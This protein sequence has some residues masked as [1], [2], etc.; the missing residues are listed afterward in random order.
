MHHLTYFFA[1]IL[2]SCDLVRTLDIQE[3]VMVTESAVVSQNFLQLY[4][5]CV[6]SPVHLFRHHKA[7]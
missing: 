2:Q 7:L 3:L 5:T 1:G 4:Y 6:E